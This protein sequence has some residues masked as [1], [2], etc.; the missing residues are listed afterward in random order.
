MSP[1]ASRKRQISRIIR[2]NLI[3]AGASVKPL[4]Y[5]TPVKRRLYRFIFLIPSQG[6]KSGLPDYIL[7]PFLVEPVG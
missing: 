2:K 4:F 6:N 7:D 3:P 5:S 1:A